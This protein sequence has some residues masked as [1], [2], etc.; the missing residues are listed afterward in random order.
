[1]ARITIKDVAREAGVS[2]ATVSLVLNDAP[3]VSEPTRERVREVMK[4]LHYRPDS[5]ARSFSSRKSQAVALV[6]PALRDSLGD[7]YYTLLLAG[8]LEVVRDRGFKLILEVADERFVRQKLWR[9]LFDGKRVDGLLVATPTMDQDYLQ[10]V[11]AR[12][13]PAMLI[14]GERPDLP[15]LDYVGFDDFR[16]GFDAAY[17]LIGLGHT[18]IAHIAGPENQASAVRR[19]AGFQEALQRARIE[20][21][22]TNLI[23]GDYTRPSGIR[24]LVKVAKLPAARRPTAIVC[25][26]DAMALGAMD[27]ATTAGLRIPE[28]LSIIG[29]DDTGAAESAGLSTFRQDIFQLGHT[30]AE[31]FLLKLQSR[32]DANP[33][34]E[35]RWP[36]QLIERASCAPPKMSV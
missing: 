30:A 15:Q 27:S 23:A 19:R 21:P 36:M 35:L 29:V 34:V 6:L 1:L 18:R 14:N 25:A 20:L 17:Y 5:L 24:A 11:A 31:R 16:C 8:V 7:P 28:Q 13:C 22:K 32:D 33:H 12:G 10:D 26:N 9:D 2:Q 4:A 3:G